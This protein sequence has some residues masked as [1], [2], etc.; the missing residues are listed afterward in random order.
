MYQIF[1]IQSFDR[2]QL[3]FLG[4]VIRNA[5]NFKS[6]GTK[7]VELSSQVTYYFQYL[8]NETHIIADYK[9]AKILKFDMLDIKL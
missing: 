5:L 6:R 1:F 2:V 3:D 9:Y 7:K 8:G 4:S